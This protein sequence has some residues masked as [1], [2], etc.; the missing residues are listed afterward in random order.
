MKIN[1]KNKIQNFKALPFGEKISLILI[2]LLS[3]SSFIV[4]IQWIAITFSSGYLFELGIF[5]RSKGIEFSDFFHVNDMVFEN[6]PYFED[7]SSYPPLVLFFAR[8]FES[9]ADYSNGYLNVL[10]QPAAQFSVI[11]YYALFIIPTTLVLIYIFKKNGFSVLQTVLFIF[12]FYFC[13]P[14]IFEFERGNYIIYALLFAL[15]FLAFYD[16]ENSLIRELS[17]I[18]LGV[19]V[20]IKLYPATLAIILLKKKRFAELFRCASYSLI[21][22]FIPFL[23]FN[24]GFSNIHRFLYFL[25][26]FSDNL[27]DYGFNYSLASTIEIFA[28]Y[29][30]HTLYKQNAT[31]SA[32]Q[33]YLPIIILLL[34]AA[35]ALCVNRTWKTFALMAIVIVQFPNISFAYALMFMLIPIISF[36]LE[37]EK[38]KRDVFY[39]ILLFATVC[40]VFLGYAIPANAIS[41]NQIIVSIAIIILE[42]CLIAEAIAFV[43]SKIKQFKNY[44]TALEY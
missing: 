21:L 16:N 22:L 19:S 34:C 33:T 40:P 32:L 42:I 38:T 15:I 31:I 36:I 14:M 3:I 28:T 12:A 30:G 1:F 11:V 20:A 18:A 7:I 27:T 26:N 29:F 6:S 37:K 25:L 24:K 10:E 35:S 2:S 4:I 41:L 43:I 39:M 8:L 13:A 9:M 23:F 44:V 5:Q 17:F